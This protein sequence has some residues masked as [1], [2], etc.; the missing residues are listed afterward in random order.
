[1]KAGLLIKQGICFCI[2]KFSGKEGYSGVL[3][4]TGKG[5]TRLWPL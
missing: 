2:L 3:Q 1:M 5:D 4:R